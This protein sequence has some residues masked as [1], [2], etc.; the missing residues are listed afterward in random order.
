MYGYD[1][2]SELQT[3]SRIDPENPPE[4]CGY[5]MNVSEA[6]YGYMLVCLDDDC[7][8][9]TDKDGLLTEPPFIRD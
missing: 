1:Y 4:H 9:H 2:D 6:P 5:A 8:M 7:E 3:G